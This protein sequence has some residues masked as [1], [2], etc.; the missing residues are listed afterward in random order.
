[1]PKIDSNKFPFPCTGGNMAGLLRFS[2]SV[3]R[4]KKC[5]MVN[6]DLELLIQNQNL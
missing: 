3:R 5:R 4:A 6:L 1:M 2:S